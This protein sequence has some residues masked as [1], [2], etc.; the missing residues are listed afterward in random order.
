MKLNSE[1]LGMAIRAKGKSYAG[2]MTLFNNWLVKNYNPLPESEIVMFM[3]QAWLES[4]LVMK[5]IQGLGNPI[6]HHF[7]MKE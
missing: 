3:W 1:V 4:Y 7:E 2:Q 6:V 5:Q